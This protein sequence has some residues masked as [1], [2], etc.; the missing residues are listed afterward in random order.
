MSS[1]SS[2]QANRKGIVVLGIFAAD[3][4]FRAERMPRMGET[5]LGQ[6]FNLGAGGKGSNQAVAAARVGG[7][8]H[9]LTRIG[10]DAFGQLALDTWRSVGIDTRHARVMAGESTGAAF[11]FVSQQ[12]GDNAII[13]T[14]GAANGLS[15]KDIDAADDA[16]ADAAVFIAQLEQPVEA[17][18]AGLRAARRHGVMTVLNPAPAPAEDL[19]DEVYGL[20]D[21]ITPNESEAEALT[22]V[23]IKNIDDARVAAQR[24]LDR[25][26]GCAVITLG[27]QGVL[28]H[29]ATQSIHVPCF[30]AGAVVDTSGAGDAFNGAFTVALAERMTTLEALRFA[31]AVAGISV[32]RP[33]TAPSMPTRAEALALLDAAP[34][35]A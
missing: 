16:L 33:G 25:G 28:L 14:G 35:P 9:L 24:L 21:Y 13:V 2:A 3:L 32:T 26:V 17:M 23:A 7:A 11:I 18:Q 4:A 10:D 6:R 22:G 15:A 29:D 19:G 1:N 34:L 12:T 31:S 5:L 20:C 27:S 30:Q 8:V